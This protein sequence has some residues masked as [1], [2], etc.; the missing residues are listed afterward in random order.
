MTVAA[1]TDTLCGC[2]APKAD[3]AYLCGTCE[4]RAFADHQPKCAFV[5]WVEV[6]VCPGEEWPRGAR[7]S[8]S[9][10]NLQNGKVR[11]WD[12]TLD[13]GYWTPGMVVRDWTGR[14][15]RVVGEQLEP[16][17]LERVEGYG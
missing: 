2:G 13:L 10:F 9:E 4:Q 11:T 16:Q 8:A 14:I 15:W 17:R 12:S 3:G 1:V 6:M 7:F 5:N